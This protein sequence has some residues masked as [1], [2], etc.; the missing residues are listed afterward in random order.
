MPHK[1]IECLQRELDFYQLP[2]LDE[3]NQSFISRDRS[4]S[5]E[6]ASKKLMQEIVD[7]IKES[8]FED[9]FPWCVYIYDQF[10]CS[11]KKSQTRVL[12]IPEAIRQSHYSYLS[13]FIKDGKHNEFTEVALVSKLHLVQKTLYPSHLEGDTL[14]TLRPP[15]DDLIGMIQE[16]AQGMG[17]LVE[18]RQLE[19]VQQNNTSNKRIFFQELPYIGCSLLR[20]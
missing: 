6:A 13:C 16:E 18:A 14:F 2:S 8:G 5:A 7:E 11:D 12:V 3:L 17:L 1:S 10:S 20:K 9:M 15:L 4:F 19:S